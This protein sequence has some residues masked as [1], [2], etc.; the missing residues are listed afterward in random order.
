MM[1]GRGGSGLEAG[2]RA[3]ERQRFTKLDG[4]DSQ[5]AKL[6]AFE[7]ALTTEGP[8]PLRLGG[9]LVDGEVRGTP[10]IPAWVRSLPAI[11]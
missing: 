4:H 1:W 9:M 11:R 10:E 6:A 3:V 2:G 8:V 5:P 7:L